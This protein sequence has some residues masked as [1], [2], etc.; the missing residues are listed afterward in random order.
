M[1]INRALWTLLIGNHQRDVYAQA[2]TPLH[3]D[4]DQ[5]RVAHRVATISPDDGPSLTPW[6]HSGVLEYIFLSVAS[7]LPL[8]LACDCVTVWG[9]LTL[10]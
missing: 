2:K 6:A 3:T 9:H 7:I 4:G 5:W 1:K 10:N 8:R